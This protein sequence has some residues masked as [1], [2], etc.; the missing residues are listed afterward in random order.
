MGPRRNEIVTK[1]IEP[2]FS[3]TTTTTKFRMKLRN[4]KQKGELKICSGLNSRDVVSNIIRLSK[5]TT[6]GTNGWKISHQRRSLIVDIKHSHYVSLIH[7][8]HSSWILFFW[9]R[10]YGIS[11]YDM[12]LSEFHQSGSE[13]NSLCS[14]C[15]FNFNLEHK[16][17]YFK[18]RWLISLS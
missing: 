2:K 1:Q 16:S 10:H 18:F 15:F 8:H 17:L 7:N 6:N 4:K 9:Y 3:T 5:H 12:F 13:L 14:N 11:A